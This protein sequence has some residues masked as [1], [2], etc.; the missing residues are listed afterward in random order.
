MLLSISASAGT[1]GSKKVD[2]SD[3]IDTQVVRQSVTSTVEMLNEVYVYPDTARR[4]GA[5]MIQRLEAGLY[6]QISSRQEFAD[7][8]GSELVE[9]SGDGHMS[10]LVAEDDEPPTHVLKETV[11]RFRHNHAFQKVEILDGNI[12][13]LK[14]NKFHQ[15]EGAQ[16]IA[17]HALGFLSG[18]DALIIDLTECKGGSPELVRHMLSY[19][20]SGGTLLW[21]II[22]R[23]GVTVDDAYSKSS[24]GSERFKSDFPL[25]VLTGPE[26]A[27]AAELFAYALKS[28]GKARTV[29]QGTNGIAHLVGVR[30]INQHFVGRFSMS[31]NINPVT[32]SDWEGVG[33]A[34]DT[35]AKPEDRLSVA[36]RMATAAVERR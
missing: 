5:E 33:V 3:A 35:H 24:V 9:L 7:R 34:P 12:G 6:D 8:I 2:Q 22:D 36:V 15:D 16:L 4:V 18:T 10:V 25:F 21:S 26:T 17:D 29:G 28:F 20:F 31:R 14:L 13:Y 32:N 11:D 19:F 30:S 1:N 27:S 23:D